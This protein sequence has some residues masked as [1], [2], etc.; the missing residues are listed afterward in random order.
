MAHDVTNC[1]DVFSP[2]KECH[3]LCRKGRERGERAE[4]SRDREQRRLSRDFAM[5]REQP[6]EKSNQIATHEIGGKCSRW[7]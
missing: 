2:G 7:Q 6:D 5:K 3:G 4:V 1:P